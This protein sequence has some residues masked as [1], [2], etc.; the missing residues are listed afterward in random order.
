MLAHRDPVELGGLGVGTDHVQRA[1]QRREFGHQPQPHTH[2]QHVEGAHGQP[3]EVAAR[4]VDEAVGQFTHHLAATAVPQ[5]HGVD[6]GAG[7][8]RGNE[9]VDLRELDQQAVEHAEQRRAQDHD[10]HRHRPGQAQLGLQAD[11]QDVP[12]HDAVAHRE[13]DLAGD[14]GN[15]GRQRQQGDHRLVR[16]DGAQVEQRGKG[17]GQHHREQQGQAH[18]EHHQAIDRDGAA[19]ALQRVQGIAVDG[20]VGLQRGRFDG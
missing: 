15:G 5:G 19:Q 16:Q 12:E 4:D 20:A 3:Q 17:V 2:G 14:H 18:G 10:Q 9:G 11:R 6:H 1:P 7:A 8:Q 13:V